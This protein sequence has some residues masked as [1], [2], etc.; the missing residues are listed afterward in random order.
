MIYSHNIIDNNEVVMI[1]S[2]D[3]VNWYTMYPDYS[4]QYKRKDGDKIVVHLLRNGYKHPVIK[5]NPFKRTRR[6]WY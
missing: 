2:V 5:A 4:V 1:V 3:D 6:K